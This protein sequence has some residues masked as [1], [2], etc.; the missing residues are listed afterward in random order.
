LRES[1]PRTSAVPL[2]ADIRFMRIL[3]AV[4][5]PAPFWPTRA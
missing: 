1:V 2:V 5:L 4:V 3:M